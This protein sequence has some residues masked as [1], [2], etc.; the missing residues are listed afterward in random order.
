MAFF[1]LFILL[2]NIRFASYSRRLIKRDCNKKLCKESVEN[3]LCEIL[4]TLIKESTIIF[5]SSTN[6]TFTFSSSKAV[7]FKKNLAYQV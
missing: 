6:Q 5:K 3:I 7:Y 4:Y 1:Y 2:K